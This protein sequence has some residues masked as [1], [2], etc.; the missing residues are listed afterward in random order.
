MKKE[1]GLK[2]IDIVEDVLTKIDQDRSTK[3]VQLATFVADFWSTAYPTII[4]YISATPEARA[5]IRQM[6]LK[7]KEMIKGFKDEN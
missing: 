4:G 5:R 1:Y 7:Q 6:L 3:N 2:F